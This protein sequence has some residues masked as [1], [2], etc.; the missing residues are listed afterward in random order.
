VLELLYTAQAQNE[1]RAI[2]TL[3]NIVALLI[4]ICIFYANIFLLGL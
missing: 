1:K 2:A 3:I 4:A